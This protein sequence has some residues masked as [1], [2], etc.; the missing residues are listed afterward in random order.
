MGF[1]RTSEGFQNIVS[2]KIRENEQDDDNIEGFWQNEVV[3]KNGAAVKKPWVIDKK[4][5]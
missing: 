3:Y 4:N 5:G 2:E 1:A